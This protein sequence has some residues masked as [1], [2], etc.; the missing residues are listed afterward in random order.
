MF[1]FDRNFLRAFLGLM[2]GFAALCPLQA[3]LDT[4]LQATKTDFLDLYQKST[5]AAL[6]P[7]VVTVFD[8][9]GSM[10]ALMFHPLYQNL[11]RDDNNNTQNMSFTLVPDTPANNTYTITATSAQNSRVWASVDLTVNSSGNVTVSN[12]QHSYLYPTMRTSNN[13]STGS[14]D[15]SVSGTSGTITLS[16]TVY[17]TN[18]STSN[19][20]HFGDTWSSSPTS[21]LSPSTHTNDVTVSRGSS[22]SRTNTTTWTVPSYNSTGT[23]AYV[24]STLYADGVS[25][26][27]VGLVTPQGTLVDATL[28]DSAT[29]TMSGVSANPKHSDIRNWVRAASHARYYAMVNGD[30][31]TIDIPIPWEITDANSTGN[32][33]SSRK[34][35]DQIVRKNVT[36]GS[37]L[38]ME[39]DSTY[40]L[41]N[42][43][44]V[45]S[46]NST[47]TTLN[48]VSHRTD[49]MGWLFTATYANGTYSNFSKKYI[50]YDA[51]DKSL[52][53]NQL[54]VSWG[55]GWGAAAAGHSIYVPKFS[56][57][58]GSYVTDVT[59][60]ASVN[61]VPGMSRIQA[62][63]RAA[64]ETWIQNQAS[65][66]WAFRFLD[67]TSEGAPNGTNIHNNSATTMNVTAGVPTSAQTGRDSGWSLLNN[68]AAQGINSTTGNSVTNMK[69]IA[70]LTAGNSTPLTYATANALAQFND[71]NNVFSAIETGNDAPSTC[72]SHFLIVFTDG[73]DNNNSGTLNP[74][75]TTPYIL[76]GAVNPLNGNQQVIKYPTSIDRLGSWWNI[77]N[78]AAVAAHMAD[79]S[80]GTNPGVDYLAATQAA[81]G[82]S[83][84][85]HSFLPFAIKKRGSVDF[86]SAGHRVTTMTVGVSLGGYYADDETA[87]PVS[88]KRALYRA[89]LL[90]DPSITSG[91]VTSFHGFD[92]ASDWIVNP[93][94]PADYPDVGLRKTGATYFFDG[95]NPEKLALM[96]QRA[97]QATQQPANINSTS[98][99]NLP[100]IGASLGKQIYLGK[101]VPPSTGGP[102]WS[103]DLLMFAT[104][105]VN[106]QTQI[107]D[108]AGNAT[109]T[110]DSTTA[111]WS[112]GA[113]LFNNRLWS[114][115]KLYT[116]LPG[117]SN[118]AEK[119]FT[120]F[121]DTGTAFTAIK[122][123]IMTKGP[124]G[125]TS[126]TTGPYPSV[127]RSP[128]V[129]DPTKQA[130]IQ[131]AMGADLKSTPDPST[132]RPTANRA[133]IMGDVIDSNPAAIPYTMTDSLK[134]QF[135]TALSTLNGDRFRLVLVGTNQGWLHA[136]GEVTK[137]TT[138]VDG[139]G[140]SQTLVKGA[141]D[142][143]WSFMPTDFLGQ[144]DYVY[145]NSSGNPHR[146]L[147]DGAP[148]IYH[149]DLPPS[150]GGSGNGTVDSTERA[151]AIIGLKKG[152][153]SYYAIDIHDPFNPSLKWS[154]CPDEVAYFPSSRIAAGG[155]P[156]TTVK[157]VLGTMGFSTASPALGRVLFNGVVRDA[158]F[159][160][161][162]YSTPDVEANFKDINGVATKLGRSVLA[163]DVYTGEVLAAV[164]MTT[165]SSTI[166][167][168]PAGVVPFEFFVNSGMAQRAYFLDYGG[169]LWSWG[170]GLTNA[171]GAFKDYRNDSSDLAMWTADGTSTGT[172]SVRKV[173]A[174]GSGN[175]AKYTTLPA[176]FRVGTFLGNGKTVS[177]VTAPTPAAVGVAMISGDRNNPVDLQYTS[178]VGSNRPTGHRLT[179]VF[180]RQDSKAWN[181]DS[182]G[183]QDTNLINFSSQ[184]EPPGT[185]TTQ[186]KLITPGSDTFYLTNGG[187]PYFGYYISL[188]G[189]G[190]SP[191]YFVP[192]GITEPIVVAGSLFYSYFKPTTVDVC[193]G[194]DGTTYSNLI[195]DV[196]RPMASDSRT[197]VTCNSGNQTTWSGVASTF[198]A[199][200][201]RGVIQGGATPVANPPIGA[202]K[203]ALSLKTIVGRQTQQ[204]PKARVWRTVH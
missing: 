115:R 196:Y 198:M 112:A 5:T 74:N 24:T 79:T 30:K 11:D 50:I 82:T 153:R 175:N 7:E 116:R 186:S 71:P 190:P 59:A 103:G 43:D 105:E 2:L 203:T 19:P 161:G 102:I 93:A 169:G 113:A 117:D 180:D 107:I 132:G 177:G 152:G 96:L 35:L 51:A 76:N 55:Q 38:Q 145:G 122:G 66:L 189:V 150:T 16:W 128:A 13:I 140:V 70:I 197:N 4:R 72:M 146:F 77:F 54:D 154:L 131:K 144:L 158:V 156:L 106:S 69:R 119:G 87:Y 10:E 44:N 126:P 148:L 92:P 90:G 185:G 97:I 155:P 108:S 174:D 98:N 57:V 170:S 165:I 138:I 78:F 22:A 89:A 151:I 166:N 104:K 195:C 37:G 61:I 68:T 109:T 100:F 23:P 88:G 26:V 95:S 12:R 182:T 118:T 129:D 191:D 84:T 204:Y 86:G 29:G 176:P 187:S 83:A 20:M 141:V 136:F 179:V 167:C 73:N 56:D 162:G 111:Q 193:S 183:I 142:E 173:A 25:P 60:D 32:P 14:S 139:S 58:D 17:I 39:L 41:N 42:G 62:V 125:T 181:L 64:I 171:S 9:S 52:V 137:D 149:L 45:L 133:N 40:T 85:P 163:L 8:F 101:F 194:G 110:L 99:P 188:P 46:A 21:T 199:Y 80:L 120:T 159:F 34:V 36:Y 201:T 124:D 47:T 28:A 200:G 123:E 63:K 157:N 160:S 49:Y 33:L 168:I 192:K 127:A 75:A 27:F 94:D 202:S 53:P 15:I 114:A 67:P 130:V 135:T 65:V 81:A 184:T 147:V 134:G 1:R 48:M 121:S 164:D 143:L 91:A 172:S 18:N 178:G 3:Q 6:K 31:R